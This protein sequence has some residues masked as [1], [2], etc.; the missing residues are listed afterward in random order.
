MTPDLL[1]APTIEA[2]ET[3]R[4]PDEPVLD[5]LAGAKSRKRAAKVAET[6]ELSE[7]L[8]VPVNPVVPQSLP[9]K[10]YRVTVNRHPEIRAFDCSA[11][12]ESEA[13]GKCVKERQLDA[14]RY[15]FTV[16]ALKPA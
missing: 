12:D 5:P 10:R 11:L 8:E 16:V 6:A 14:S 13:I 15:S 4:D 2:E 7:V 9:F 3:V 1:E